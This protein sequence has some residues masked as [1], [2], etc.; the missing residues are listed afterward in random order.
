MP[1]ILT[2]FDLKRSSKYSKTLFTFNLRKKGPVEKAPDFEIKF[3]IIFD[4]Y[5][6]KFREILRPIKGATISPNTATQ[7]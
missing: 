4:N 6:R 7:Y 2:F 5:Y 1:N 3:N